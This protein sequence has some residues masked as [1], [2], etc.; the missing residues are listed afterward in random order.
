M[1]HDVA[2][3]Q[4]SKVDDLPASRSPSGPFWV[5]FI[6]GVWFSCTG[7]LA[8][9]PKPPL[10]RSPYIQAASPTQIHVLWRTEGPIQ[11]VVRWGSRP[12]QLDRTVP[13]ELIVTRASLGTNGQTLLPRWQ[14]LRNEMLCV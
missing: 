9:N 13:L 6:L 1:N 4:V 5:F 3:K 7:V 14:A 10:S 2:G 8:A 12:D 11:P